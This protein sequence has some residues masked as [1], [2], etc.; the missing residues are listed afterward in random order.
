MIS[1]LKKISDDN[2]STNHDNSICFSDNDLKNEISM[3]L[4]SRPIYSGMEDLPYICDSVINYGINSSLLNVVSQEE[5][6]IEIM[7]R[8]KIALQR[9]EPRISDVRVIH[10]ET[11]DIRSVFTVKSCMFSRPLTFD[12]SWTKATDNLSLHE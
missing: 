11:N 10:K 7:K 3:L 4:T 8:I 1:F 2:P 6:K 9:F 12:V 5:Q